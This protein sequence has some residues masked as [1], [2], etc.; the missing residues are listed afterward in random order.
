MCFPPWLDPPGRVRNPGLFSSISELACPA[1]VHPCPEPRREKAENK[2]IIHICG[3]V[4]PRRIS[5]AT[6]LCGRGGGK[7]IKKPCMR[8]DI[9]YVYTHTTN[10]SGGGG[11]YCYTCL[12]EIALC[13]LG[14]KETERKRNS[15]LP[16]NAWQK[17][18]WPPVPAPAPRPLPAYLSFS[19]PPLPGLLPLNYPTT[20]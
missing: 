1:P 3:G 10:N 7:G 8:E 4:T 17:C 2:H 16:S 9:P 15:L 19:P 11:G 20:H 14:T 5:A 12:R 18:I 13:V 6:M